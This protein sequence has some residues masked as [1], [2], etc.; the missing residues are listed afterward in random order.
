MPIEIIVGLPNLSEG[1]LLA[2]A[3]SMQVPV[4][5]SANCLSRWVKRDGWR[6]WRGW[7]LGPLAN[8]RGLRS[9]DL[10]SAGFVLAS[11]LRGIPWTVED[12][13][14]GLAAAYPWRRWA[15]LDHCVEEE[16][17]RDREEVLDR[18]ARTVRLNIECHA[19]AVDAGITSTFM[20]VI[21]GR[22]PED[23]LRC[24]DGIAH[25]LRPD[26][27]VGVGSTCRRP[28]HGAE[29]LL[30]VFSL[31]DQRLPASIFL[32]GFGIK[33][34]SL[35]HLR[36]LE[37]RIVSCDSQAFGIQ[38][39][40][41]AFEAGLRKSNRFVADH[42]EDWTHRQ[43]ERLARPAMAFQ[44]TLPLPQPARPAASCW[45]AAIAGAREQIRTLIEQGEI[46]HDQITDAWIA[47]WAA[48]LLE[49]A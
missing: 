30:A 25:L 7:R 23:F 44:S 29:G 28:A 33:G 42:M 2:R 37:H 18:I 19:R 46:S 21:Q 40:R 1:P 34:S 26:M 31:L 5:I 11:K 13:V 36:G 35:S 32:H 4:L 3:R 10:D 20:P 43:H 27:V 6:E 48:D 17:A 14:D 15:S 45:E 22:H 12:Y 24:I 49:A 47:E 38:A 16:I 39:R 41:A 8:A 9:I